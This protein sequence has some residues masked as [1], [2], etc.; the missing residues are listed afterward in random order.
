MASYDAEIRVKTSL[1]N[2]TFK[3]EAKKIEKS[4]AEIEKKASGAREKL[5]ALDKA[6]ISKTSQQYKNAQE[7]LLRWS[8]A[9]NDFVQQREEAM[10]RM[11]RGWNPKKGSIDEDENYKNLLI[12]WQDASEK[13]RQFQLGIGQYFENGTE[14]IHKSVNS[15]K[16]DAS[17]LSEH[18]NLMK[19]DIEQ[20]ADNLKQ[21]EKEGKYF[22]DADYDQMYRYWK[23][24]VD[25]AKKYQAELNK[26]T[27]KG[28]AEEA[29]K[30]AKVLE[31]QEAT[32][33]RVEAQAEKNL[34]R[35]NVTIQKEAEKEAKLRA[36][37][38][39]EQRLAQIKANATASDQRIIS[40]LERRKQLQAEIADLEKAGVTAGYQEY[41]ARQ[42][43]LKSINTRVSSSSDLGATITHVAAIAGKVSKVLA[44]VG[45][46]LGVVK[47]IA[48][49]IKTIAV[50]VGKIVGS[51]AKKMASAFKF[52]ATQVG[53]LFQKL[54]A[55]FRSGN[56]SAGNFGDRLLGLV[57]SVFIFNV[58]S[59]AFQSMVSGVQDSTKKFTQYSSGFNRDISS[60]VNALSTLKNA[61]A[62]AFA[63]ILSVAIPYLV[64]LINYVTMAVNAVAQL[65]AA[66]TGASTW[67]KATQQNKDYAA[68]L[69]K[70]GGS[71]KKTAGALAKF[72]DLDVLQKQDNTGGGGGGAG[73]GNMWEEVPVS[74]ATKG[75][76]DK[77][78]KLLALDDW[79][80]IGKMI[81]GKLTEMLMSIPW[82][83]IQA[84]AA[85]LGK[86]LGSL[87]NGI[88]SDSRLWEE[89]GYAL[90]QG[91]NT[92]LIFLVNFLSQFDFEK[93]G[94]NIA[95]GL[96]TAFGNIDWN[97]LAQTIIEGINGLVDLLYGFISY[98]D[99]GKIGEQLGE[100]LFTI[101]DN[102]NYERAAETIIRGIVKISDAIISFIK[103]ID[104]KEL[105]NHVVDMMRR[106]VRSMELDAEGNELGDIWKKNGEA[107]GK[108][109]QAFVETISTLMSGFAENGSELGKQIARWF[110]NAIAEI[111]WE[112]VGQAIHDALSGLLDVILGFLEEMDWNAVGENIGKFLEGLDWKS[113]T[114][115]L[116]EALRLAII[117]LREILSDEF[118]EDAETKA[119]GANIILGVIDGMLGAFSPLVKSI[120]DIFQ[121]I[122]LAIRTFLGIHS[123][124]TVFAEIGKFLIEGLLLG[125]QEMWVSLQ[126]WFV[127]TFDNL[128]LFF[129]EKWNLIKD[130]ALE[131]WNSLKDSLA[132]TWDSIKESV[133][134]KFEAVREK[135]E[136]VWNAVKECVDLKVKDIKGKVKELNDKFSEFKKNVEIVFT[137]IKNS[138][139]NALSPVIDKLKEFIQW[140]KDAIQAVKD[141]F[142][143]G[144]E[145]VGTTAG[146]TS[147]PPTTRGF[148]AA[149]P[150]SISA[151]MADI[152]HLASGAVLRGGNP[153]LA[154]LGDQRAGQTNIEAPLSTIRQ[155]VRDELSG[156]NFGG[157]QLKVVLQ[158][159]GADLAQA[160]LQDFLSE[161][162]RQGLDVEVLGV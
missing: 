34:Q 116:G 16:A 98:I 76:A 44:I 93:I 159:N 135:F 160:T 26:H 142:G 146:K 148:M 79:S 69:D 141:F 59:K 123:P 104:F 151:A 1:D 102:L 10:H 67:S 11:E 25:G 78:K 106:I 20:Y 6:G 29:E 111:N 153:F 150:A 3:V 118:A 113:I 75:L 85:K 83:T 133:T 30:A 82:D 96:N 52:V 134:E 126:E 103:A 18:V 49:V 62:G 47:K 57:K 51:L 125:I 124:S 128:I 32:Q 88:L 36:Q 31:K 56:K 22:G 112:E 80:E 7:E 157:G 92:A 156:M 95:D 144:Y 72:D 161:M 38:A 64:Q 58:I 19:M 41:D 108:L 119:I 55:G 87:L 77:I 121:A 127:A 101:L 162:N 109:I 158:V 129:S 73:A 138:I 147:K 152:P 43:E 139:V 122:I 23:D 17:Q 99:L 70:V 48:S 53:K 4:L 54:T 132:E 89:L 115:K 105:S 63:P 60:L 155:A 81:A 8:K 12:S 107:V 33:R 140:V 15:Q 2:Q 117:S 46:V 68:S 120:I 27:E 90:A 50:T 65:I 143:S 74:D 145:Q 5:D 131:I 94:N 45:A 137:N 100:T 114:E 154:V 9:L 66:L 61:I 84:A 24:A 28:Q 136:E 97:L 21:L 35:E 86:Q 13:V 37:E 14:K 71:A 130:G 40:L 91:I 39:E 110:G 149:S 42:A